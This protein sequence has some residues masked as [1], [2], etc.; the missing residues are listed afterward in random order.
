MGVVDLVA[1]AVFLYF[2]GGDSASQMIALCLVA[3]GIFYV[4]RGV[5]GLRM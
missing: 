1:A 4:V 2:R 5:L 3:L